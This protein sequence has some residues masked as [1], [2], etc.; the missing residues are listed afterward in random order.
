[1]CITFCWRRTVKAF[2]M[3]I[4]LTEIENDLLLENSI[5]FITCSFE[6]W[7]WSNE[8]DKT[9]ISK[10]DTRERK[11]VKHI[12]TDALVSWTNYIYF[13]GY[14]TALSFTSL[15]PVEILLLLKT[16]S[17]FNFFYCSFSIF[18]E[19]FYTTFWEI[20]KLTQFLHVKIMTLLN[21]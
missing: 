3:L 8:S 10:S 6:C 11:C 19:S 13:H 15:L 14:S 5:T 17:K 9:N 1:M 7:N 4:Y 2:F 18:S 20:L 21:E 16:S 12:S